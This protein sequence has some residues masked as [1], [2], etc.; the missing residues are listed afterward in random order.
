[1]AL[2]WDSD[3]SGPVKTS[4][5]TDRLTLERRIET[6]VVHIGYLETRILELEGWRSSYEKWA[7]NIYQNVVPIVKWFKN[8]KPE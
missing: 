4:E 5:P 8:K 3:W 1:M 7:M 6:L 2:Q